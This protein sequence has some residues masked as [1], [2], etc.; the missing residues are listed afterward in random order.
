[1]QDT[2]SS[3]NYEILLCSSDLSNLTTLMFSVSLMLSFSL[4]MKDTRF[5]QLCRCSSVLCIYKLIAWFV[6]LLWVTTDSIWSPAVRCNVC[7]GVLE[8]VLACS[9]GFWPSFEP[10]GGLK[11]IWLPF[12]N[13]QDAIITAGNSCSEIW[14]IYNGFTELSSFEFSRSLHGICS[15]VVQSFRRRCNQCCWLDNETFQM[16]PECNLSQRGKQKIKW[17]RGAIKTQR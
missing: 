3:T 5:L 16:F 12:R 8:R 6:W 7:Q 13:C 17:P 14:L 10:A 11:W 4:H 1:M 2:V 9:D 15:D